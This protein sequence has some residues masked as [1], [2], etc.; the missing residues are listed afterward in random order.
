MGYYSAESDEDR[1]YKRLK[2]IAKIKEEMQ[3]ESPHISE[4]EHILNYEDENKENDELFPPRESNNGVEEQKY[5]Y[6]YDIRREDSS[7]NS[8][9][10]HFI[11]DR[12]IKNEISRTE[13]EAL[14][15]DEEHVLNG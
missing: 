3:S 13:S 5:I 14:E 2:K 1:R 7:E 9:D 4:T 12:S 6:I 10:R 15:T 8:V 11:D